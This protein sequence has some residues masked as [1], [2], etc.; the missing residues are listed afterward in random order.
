MAYIKSCKHFNMKSFS[1]KAD[2]I[3]MGDMLEIIFA[4]KVGSQN[5]RM[6]HCKLRP[7]SH[8]RITDLR[9][10][11]VMGDTYETFIKISDKGAWD[12]QNSKPNQK[13][14]YLR[15]F[16]GSSERT[17]SYETS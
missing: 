14:S 9:Q 12:I 15:L 1:K 17:N 5:T 2:R 7:I 4:S 6:S 10:D 8:P 3:P 13:P 11:N 16:Y